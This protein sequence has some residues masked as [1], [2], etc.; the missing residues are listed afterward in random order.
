MR[1][2]SKH[3]PFFPIFVFLISLALLEVIFFYPKSIYTASGVILLLIV[4]TLKSFTDESDVAGDWWNFSILPVVFQSALIAYATMVSAGWIV[5]ILFILSCFF[6]YFYL[7]ACYLYLLAPSFYQISSIE[8]FSQLGNFL[9]VYFWAAA[10]FGL[11]IIIGASPWLMVL[12]L[13]ALVVTATHQLLWAYKIGWKKASVYALVVCLVMLEIG[14][15]LS[16]LPL[17]HNVTGLILSIIFYMAIGLTRLAI[18]RK[19]DKKLVK[20]YLW[21]G[22]AAIVLLLITSRWI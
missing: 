21:Y 12:F 5:H 4:G 9:F 6:V 17:N 2:L 1:F 18:S 8:H 14:W 3:N 10:I 19:L 22:F 11:E 15:S 16:Y 13:S 7:R 20:S